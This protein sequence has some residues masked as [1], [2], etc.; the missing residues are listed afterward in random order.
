[1][2]VLSGEG[3]HIGEAYATAAVLLVFVTLMNG[4]S[5]WISRRI[6]KE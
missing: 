4:L 1:M 6:I 2:Y 5:E 3:L